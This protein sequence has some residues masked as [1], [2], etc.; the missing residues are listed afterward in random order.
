MTNFNHATFLKDSFNFKFLIS[1]WGIYKRKSF[2]VM[3]KKILMRQV[4]FG[5]FKIMG[6]ILYQQCQCLCKNA[7]IELFN[8][9]F[10]I[11]NYKLAILES[12]RKYAIRQQ[13]FRNYF[14]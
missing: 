9:T 10:I 14:F 5:I 3:K 7:K 12:I 13:S 1:L 8:S 6:L 4:V 2:C 11:W